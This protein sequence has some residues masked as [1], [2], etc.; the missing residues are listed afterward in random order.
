MWQSWVK[1]SVICQNTHTWQW[2]KLHT[3]PYNRMLSIHV[4][5]HRYSILEKSMHL[6]RW[7]IILEIISFVSDVPLVNRYPQM[8]CNSVVIPSH[9]VVHLM[10]KCLVFLKQVHAH[11][12]LVWSVYVMVIRLN[13]NCRFQMTTLTFPDNALGQWPFEPSG[14]GDHNKLT[15]NHRRWILQ[16]IQIMRAFQI[17]YFNI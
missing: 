5:E 9:R 2:A 8:S 7:T 6:T 11:C 15:S 14:P 10:H 12:T 1:Q 17:I 3:T 4:I 16:F 13:I